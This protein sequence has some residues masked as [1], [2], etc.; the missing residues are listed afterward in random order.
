MINFLFILFLVFSVLNM[1][2]LFIILNLICRRMLRG[3]MMSLDWF[4][5]ISR[6]LFYSMAIYI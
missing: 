1:A 3:E 4:K 6:F 2:V 5:Y